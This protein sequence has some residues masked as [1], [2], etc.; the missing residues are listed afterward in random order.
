MKFLV[1]I[2]NGKSAGYFICIV[3]DKLLKKKQN[4]NYLHIIKIYS[5]IFHHHE[6]PL[7]SICAFTY[8][9]TKL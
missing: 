1:T 4:T 5:N 2:N 8:R 6:T 7:L 3:F 9:R